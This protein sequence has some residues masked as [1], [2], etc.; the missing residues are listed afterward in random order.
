MNRPTKPS[1]VLLNCEAV[2]FAAMLPPPAYFSSASANPFSFE[3]RD[4]AERTFA[5]W[6]ERFR[7]DPHALRYKLIW[8]LSCPTPGQPDYVWI[9]RAFTP[10]RFAVRFAVVAA[11]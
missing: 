6:Y 5:R 1:D 9:G 7:A 8:Q 4:M 10:D 2:N 11:G 3:T